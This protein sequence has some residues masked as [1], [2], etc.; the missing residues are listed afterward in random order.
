[1]LTK[2]KQLYYWYK[3]WRVDKPTRGLRSSK[4]PN[5]RKQHIQK[6]PRCQWCGGKLDLEV[7]HIEPYHI[8]PT[9]ELDQT[10]LITLCEHGFK[11]CHRRRGHHNNWKL[12]NPDIRQQCDERKNAT[13]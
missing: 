5:T 3:D 11:D 4:W 6:E 9:R 8:N 13:I 2:L 10:N 1:M 7:H 12:S